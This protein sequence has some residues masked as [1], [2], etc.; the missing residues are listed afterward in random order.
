MKIHHLSCGTICPRFRRW[1]Q[2]EGGIFS[3][4]EIICHCLLIE[5]E[6]SGLVLVDTGL[7]LED[8]R[9]P[10]ERMGPVRH[11]MKPVLDEEMTALRQVEA[12][13]F[14]ARDVRHIVLTHLDFD[15]A[16][17]L[18]DFPEAKVH[19]LADEKN[20]ALDPPTKVE[21]QRYRQLQWD[22]DPIWRSYTPEGEPWR[23]FDIVRE[24]DGLPPEILLLPM[25]GHSR[26]HTAVAVDAGAEG[27]LIHAGDAYFYRGEMEQPPSCTGG[28]R[29][30][31]KAAAVD[32][33][34]R[35]ANLERLRELRYGHDD[36]QVFCAHDPAELAALRG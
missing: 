3:R 10:V 30:F 29:F 20:A 23:G 4:A 11:L 14:D 21:K 27:W 2:G 25:P 15:H 17:G 33:E 28:L 22:H 6:S 5:T 13:G 18:T 1:L 26:G 35:L 34:L 36:V 8:M 31:Q 9:N 7:G 19:L 16:G 12:M 24:L 32:H